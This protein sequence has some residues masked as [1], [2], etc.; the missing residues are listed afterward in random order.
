MA[1]ETKV[2]SELKPWTGNICQYCETP[3]HRTEREYRNC[4]TSHVLT[5]QCDGVEISERIDIE[6]T[7]KGLSHVLGIASNDL[8]RILV[9]S[10]RRLPKGETHDGI[11]EIIVQ[12]LRE[13]PATAALAN[14][15][16]RTTV[17]D[18]WRKYRVRQH[19]GMDS[20][21]DKIETIKAQIDEIDAYVPTWEADLPAKVQRRLAKQRTNRKAALERKIQRQEVQTLNDAMVS[22]VDWELRSMEKLDFKAHWKRLPVRIREI[23]QKRLSGFSLDVSERKTL[24]RFA[25][26][27]DG[28]D[29]LMSLMGIS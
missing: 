12:L 1:T 26:S 24:S 14:T 4:K 17:M 29:F 3:L 19:F 11:Q 6:E 2:E 5:M 13:K 20:S 10:I 22:G 25:T 28:Q 23:V 8:A 27:D 15:V 9:Y 16:A 21:L 7:A 18:Y